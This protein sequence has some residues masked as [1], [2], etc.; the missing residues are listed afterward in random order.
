MLFIGIRYVP[1]SF[2]PFSACCRYQFYRYLS[3]IKRDT[4]TLEAEAEASGESGPQPATRERAAAASDASL[5]RVEFSVVRLVSF[6]TLTRENAGQT[7]TWTAIYC[8]VVYV[9]DEGK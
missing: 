3:N 4:N 9:F 6:H 2:V 7:W 1:F 8:T 5:I